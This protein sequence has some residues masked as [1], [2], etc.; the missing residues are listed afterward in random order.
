[1]VNLTEKNKI[2]WSNDQEKHKKEDWI[3]LIIRGRKR[4]K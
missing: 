1:M 4:E 3:R 2:K